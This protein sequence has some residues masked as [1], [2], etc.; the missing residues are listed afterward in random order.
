MYNFNRY[1]VAD[2]KNN[3][4]TVWWNSKPNET[5]HIDFTKTAAAAWYTQRLRTLQQEAGID[6][7]KF[8]AGESSWTPP[9]YSI[10]FLFCITCL[11]NFK[12]ENKNDRIQY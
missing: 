4:D 10:L 7:F 12:I 1:L 2:H 3:T 9:V 11:V 8:D 6:S 5:A